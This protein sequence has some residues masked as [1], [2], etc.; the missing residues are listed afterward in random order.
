MLAG[1]AELLDIG[2]DLEDG[3]AH[4]AAARCSGGSSPKPGSSDELE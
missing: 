3:R 1:L 2:D 4:A